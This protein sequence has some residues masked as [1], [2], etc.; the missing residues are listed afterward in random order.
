MLIDMKGRW[1]MY[2]SR[3][4][5]D[6]RS[7][8]KAAEAGLDIDNG[9]A[10]ERFI[11]RRYP[12]STEEC[13][14]ECRARGVIVLDYAL[15]E[16][17]RDFS[18]KIGGTAVFFA[19]DVD[20]LLAEGFERPRTQR[21]SDL[22]YSIETG[23]R[24]ATFLRLR[25]IQREAS[26]AAQAEL[27]GVGLDEVRWALGSPPADDAEARLR[28]A[29]V[30]LNAEDRAHVKATIERDRGT[31]DFTKFIADFAD[32][33][34]RVQRMVAYCDANGLVDEDLKRKVR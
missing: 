19:S 15:G 7:L 16:Y 13:K 25:D 1:S 34:A 24:L 30:A 12:L 29:N 6:R 18:R 8:I 22:V 3:N 2:L 32:R 17:A 23:V 26:I 11:E 33:R 4:E 27:A 9:P 14:A 10:F 5:F 20:V 28:F 31:P 21:T